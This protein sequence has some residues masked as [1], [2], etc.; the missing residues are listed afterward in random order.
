MSRFRN[1]RRVEARGNFEIL[2][3]NEQSSKA[4]QVIRDG[5]RV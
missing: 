4:K 1:L 5:A 2:K 3:E